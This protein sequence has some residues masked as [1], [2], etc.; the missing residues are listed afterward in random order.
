MSS[1]DTDEASSVESL[2]QVQKQPEAVEGYMPAA[3]KKL[4][5]V[6]ALL[7]LFSA[8]LASQPVPNAFRWSLGVAIDDRVSAEPRSIRLFQTYAAIPLTLTLFNQSPVDMVIDGEA[9][10]RGVSVQMRSAG[11]QVPIRV[12]WADVVRHAGAPSEVSA[13]TIELDHN[14]GGPLR[15][16]VWNIHVTRVDGAVF[17]AGEYA[18]DVELGGA[19]TAL[20]TSTGE[21][22]RGYVIPRNT[23]TLTMAESVDDAERVQRF[24]QLGFRALLDKRSAEAEGLALKG[25]AIKP[26]HTGLLGLLA[27]AYVQ[28]NRY[29]EAIPLYERVLPSLRD[30]SSVPMMLA[31]AYVGIGDDTNAIRALKLEG[32]SD[33]G[34]ASELVRLREVVKRRGVPK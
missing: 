17:E 7:T 32:R 27:D 28:Q 22:F 14:Q 5:Y 20:N 8:P 3:G 12:E 11:R 13:H 2:R 34:A 10:R 1:F 29:R 19:V 16:V 4:L 33:A 15:G 30:R 9:F 24:Q 23:V 31:L 21:P 25:L 18:I 6:V 26:D